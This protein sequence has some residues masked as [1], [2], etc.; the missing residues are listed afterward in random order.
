MRILRQG[1]ACRRTVQGRRA[2]ADIYA[3]PRKDVC[4][5][6]FM[7]VRHCRDCRARTD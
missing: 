5:K 2:N 4:F 3:E 1:H 7:D 6:D